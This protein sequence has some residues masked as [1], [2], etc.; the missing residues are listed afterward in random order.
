[1]NSLRLTFNKRKN[2]ENLCANIQTKSIEIRLGYQ[3][4]RRSIAT[5]N[6]QTNSVGH[7]ATATE[8]EQTVLRTM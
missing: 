4:Q 8:V 7:S 2:E 6:K 3:V 1:M 5:G